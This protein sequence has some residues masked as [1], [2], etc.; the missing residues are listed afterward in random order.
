MEEVKKEG[1]EYVPPIVYT[2]KQLKSYSKLAIQ[3]LCVTNADGVGLRKNMKHNKV[4]TYKQVCT[5]FHTFCK[6]SL[7]G[8]LCLDM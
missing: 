3:T 8:N 1:R 6:Y 5:N 4:S 2:E 7:P